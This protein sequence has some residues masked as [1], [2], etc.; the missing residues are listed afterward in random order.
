MKIV[1]IQAKNY[2]EAGEA[3]AKKLPGECRFFLRF[4]KKT[5]PK[6]FFLSWKK[7]LLYISPL[8]PQIK[9]CT[10]DAWEYMN[11][12][13]Q[14]SK[15]PL[16]EI[17]AVNA[18]DLLD[19]MHHKKQGASPKHCTTILFRSKIQSWLAYTDEWD[20]R[21]RPYYI[22]LRVKLP[23]YSFSAF[24]FPL[25]LPGYITGFNSYGLVYASNTLHL[26]ND[27]YGIPLPFALFSL[28]KS[29]TSSQYLRSLKT[30]PLGSSVNINFLERQSIS[31]VEYRRDGKIFIQKKINGFLVHANHPVPKSIFQDEELR[32][33]VRSHARFNRATN[34]MKLGVTEPKDAIKKIISD[35]QGKYPIFHD[36]VLLRA[37]Y[38]KKLHTVAYITDKTFTLPLP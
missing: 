8:L 6:R 14:G 5:I 33:G 23:R 30:M 31:L 35:T 10:P 37:C 4:I 1:A 11:G 17:F 36:D 13:S 19:N 16:I 15:T 25:E 28:H 32:N 26:K 2:R 9:K 34:L 21:Y 7:Y 12:I 3:V 29:K 22:L 20:K 27:G 18:Y 24:T 38:D